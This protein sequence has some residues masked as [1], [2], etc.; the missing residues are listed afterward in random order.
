M[1][2]KDHRV[3]FM[4]CKG[5]IKI[6]LTRDTLKSRLSVLQVGNPFLIKPLGSITCD[7][8]CKSKPTLGNQRTCAKEAELHAMFLHL[9]VKNIK[10]ECEW[11]HG[12]TA[13]RT[14]IDKH[15]EPYDASFC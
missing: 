6:G 4:E 2:K 5:F 9:Q 1:S 11:F 10:P 14:Y 15:A 3:Y 12:N 8:N 13:L 7:C